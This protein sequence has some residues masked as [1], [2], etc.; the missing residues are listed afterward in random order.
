M[1]S[2]REFEIGPVRIGGQSPLVVIAGPCVIESEEHAG[3]VAGRLRDLSCELGLPLIFKASYDKANRP[4][5]L[6]IAALDCAKTSAFW[7]R[8]SRPPAC[9]S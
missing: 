7:P 2:V 9:R 5:S 4:H 8:S 6:P 3:F 1:S